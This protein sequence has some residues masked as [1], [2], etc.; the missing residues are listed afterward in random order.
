MLRDNFRS[1]IFYNCI[2]HKSPSIGLKDFVEAMTYLYSI[3]L[4]F[5]T[6]NILQI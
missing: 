1:I 4:L 5:P 2:A 3:T 6:K